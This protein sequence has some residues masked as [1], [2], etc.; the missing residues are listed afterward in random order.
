MLIDLI[1]FLL[2]KMK[3]FFFLSNIDG[4]VKQT[5][6][7]KEISIDL[8][9]CVYVYLNCENYINPYIIN[10]VGKGCAI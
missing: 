8:V 2:R 10:T 4:V 3:C 5:Y 9:I 6:I 1:F 7:Y